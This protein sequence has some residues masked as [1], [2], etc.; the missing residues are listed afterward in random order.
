MVI[1]LKAETKARLQ[2]LSTNS[3]RAPEEIVEDAV[4]GYLAEFTQLR[5]RLDGRY[6]EIVSGRVAA[7]DGEEAFKRLGREKES[8]FAKY[9]G[10]GNPGI[11]KGR[12]GI[13]K[14]LREARGKLDEN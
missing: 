1:H 6:D 8:P 5:E 10:I 2:K 7:M 4:A 14:W 3:G 9:M 11:G 13:R 12:K